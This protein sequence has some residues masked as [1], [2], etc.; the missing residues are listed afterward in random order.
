MGV[1]KC[2][3]LLRVVR[4]FPPTIYP[5]PQG[6]RAY[7]TPTLR[8]RSPHD[9]PA[10]VGW[11]SRSASVSLCVVR[12]FASRSTPPSRRAGLRHTHPTFP[13]ASLS[14]R[15]RRMGV[16]KCARLLRGVRSLAPRFTPPFKAGGLTPHP[17]YVSVPLT[18]HP[19]PVG[20]ASRSASV[21]L[22]VVRT[23]APRFT[24]PLKAGGLAPHPPYVSVPL[25][26][27]PKPVG[28]ASRSASV[29]CAWFAPSPHDLPHP[30]SQ[31]RPLD[32]PP[33]THH[34]DQD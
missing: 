20:W 28:W 7:A 19:K 23:F 21:S 11:A 18:I 6:G 3:R 25:T 1:T 13:F 29:F 32:K 14:T 24:P 4:T 10:P 33:Q 26:I 31:K 9:L 17:P 2:A 5:T 27:Y 30:T 22:C 15:P 12:T 34:C 8:F 16:T